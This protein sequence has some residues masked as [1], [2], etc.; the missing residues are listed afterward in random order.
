MRK[1]QSVHMN[2][3]QIKAMHFCVL[4][5]TR[6]TNMPVLRICG[7]HKHTFSCD[8]H[9]KADCL[10]SL[11]IFADPNK[12]EIKHQILKCLYGGLNWVQSCTP[13]Y[14]LTTTLLSPAVPLGQLLVWRRQAECTAL[15]AQGQ[16]TGQPA[17]M[18]SW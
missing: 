14:G 5:T 2:D 11:Q 15:T 9:V 13:S 8:L 18:S 4:R 1:F 16:L 17:V 7:H 6:T 3:F 10:T 12:L